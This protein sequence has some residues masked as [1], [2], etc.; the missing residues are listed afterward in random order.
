MMNRYVAGPII[1]VLILVSSSMGQTNREAQ[2]LYKRGRHRYSKGD[3]EGAIADFTK[4]I[5][6]R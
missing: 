4:A 5:S 1:A 2:D 3:V 6:L